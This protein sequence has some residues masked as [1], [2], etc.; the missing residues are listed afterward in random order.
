MMLAMNLLGYDAMTLGNHE[1]NFG[2]KNLEKARS[3]ARFPWLSANTTV[4]PGGRE[5]PFAPYIVKTVAGVK[6]AVIGITTPAIPGWEKPEN[7]GSYRFPPPVDVL[8]KTVAELRA[9]EHPDLIVVAAHSGLGRDL[10]T[11]QP[12]N[13][14]ENV[15]YDLAAGRPRYG[16]HRLRPFAQP[17][18]RTIGWQGSGGATARTGRSPW[19]AWIS[20]WNRSRAAA[21]PWPR[22][23]AA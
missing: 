13:P 21:G 9:R 5:R 22:R 8:K 17:T 4:A 14:E 18:G 3:D 11:G 2:L 12:E 16:R 10:D 20:R 7:I 19:R 1:F 15:V 6:V 23:R